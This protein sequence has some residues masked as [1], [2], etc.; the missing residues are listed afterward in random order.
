MCEDE[1]VYINNI[2]YY[3]L[4]TDSIY[5]KHFYDKYL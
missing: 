4:Y 1:Q 5:W 3:I 2:G